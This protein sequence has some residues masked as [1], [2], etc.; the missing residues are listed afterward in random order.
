MHDINAYHLI[1]RERHSDDQKKQVIS[2]LK[3]Q[4]VRSMLISFKQYRITIL[5]IAL[6]YGMLFAMSRDRIQF[7]S[8]RI[9]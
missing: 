2:N 4:F 5:N 3:I 7:P 8:I 1:S 6:A 9:S